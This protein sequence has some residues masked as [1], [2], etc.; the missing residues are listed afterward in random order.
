M[1]QKFNRNYILINLGKFIDFF[2]FIYSSSNEKYVF[3][4]SFFITFFPQLQ[5]IFQYFNDIYT[6]KFIKPQNNCK[7]FTQ[8]ETFSSCIDAS[9]H[10]YCLKFTLLSA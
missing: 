1:S 5:I 3:P 7:F 4:N 10:L 2:H 9:L 8:V 6:L